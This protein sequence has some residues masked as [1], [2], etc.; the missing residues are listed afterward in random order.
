MNVLASD[1][2]CHIQPTQISCNPSLQLAMQQFILFHSLCVHLLNCNMS[3][4][5]SMIKKELAKASFPR[6]TTE[7]LDIPMLN[8]TSSLTNTGN[9]TSLETAVATTNTPTTQVDLNGPIITLPLSNSCEPSNTVPSSSAVS[10]VPSRTDRKTEIISRDNL[11]HTQQSTSVGGDHLN[12]KCAITSHQF[13]QQ[14]KS[15]YLCTIIAKCT[16]STLLYLII[17]NKHECFGIWQCLPCSSSH[18]CALTHPYNLSVWH[19]N[20]FHSLSVYL[21]HCNMSPQRSMTNLNWP[22]PACLGKLLNH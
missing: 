7:S 6:E 2:V 17:C 16:V 10:S 18:K 19:F 13:V 11:A 12:G 4:Q 21:L 14:P 5:T 9:I 3:F 8:N 20:L 22:K 1:Y 15:T